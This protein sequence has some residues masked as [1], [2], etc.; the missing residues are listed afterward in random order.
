M[1]DGDA[2][3]SE[4]LFKDAFVLEVVAIGAVQIIWNLRSR[5]LR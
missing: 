4:N 2:R 1:L 5:D 3:R